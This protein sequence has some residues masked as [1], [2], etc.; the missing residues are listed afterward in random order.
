MEG[1][2]QQLKDSASHGTIE[3][4]EEKLDLVKDDIERLN[5]ELDTQKKE[6][7]ELRCKIVKM[8]KESKFCEDPFKNVRLLYISAL[9]K[10]LN[11]LNCV[12][13]FF[14]LLLLS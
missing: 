7:E 1:L 13:H 11:W 12:S 2:E 10:P 8:E 9:L 3:N 4:L 5:D 14:F 6:N